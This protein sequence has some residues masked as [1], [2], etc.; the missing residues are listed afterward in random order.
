MT[1]I[2]TT[3]K[4]AIAQNSGR[5]PTRGSSHCTGRVDASIPSDPLINIHELAR[6]KLGTSSQRLKPLSGAIRQALTPMPINTRPASR[7][8]K[9]PALE[10]AKQPSTATAKK[11]VM[12]RFGP[13]L[14]SH[15]PSGNW[16]A[17]KPKK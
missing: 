12:T 14:S 7:P 5:H 15:V 4:A 16:V 1:S 3:S 13:Y 17:A 2:A 6:S 11:H 9:L 8:A 10:N